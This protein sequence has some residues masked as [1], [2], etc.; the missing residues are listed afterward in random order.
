[1]S[2]A[3]PH[4]REQPGRDEQQRGAEDAGRHREAPADHEVPVEVGPAI[5]GKVDATAGGDQTRTRGLVLG[6][7]EAKFCK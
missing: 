1:M 5:K 3:L 6:C 2:L 4:E 7:I